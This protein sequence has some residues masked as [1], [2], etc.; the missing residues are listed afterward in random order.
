MKREEKK[1]TECDSGEVE[2]VKHFLM[3][4]KAWNG[5]REKLMEHKWSTNTYIIATLLRLATLCTHELSHTSPAC[6]HV[7][8]LLVCSCLSVSSV[9]SFPAAA[10]S[11]GVGHP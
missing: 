7:N 5:E 9:F 11:H 8:L 3:I 2:D 10:Y 1:C 6:R 4:C